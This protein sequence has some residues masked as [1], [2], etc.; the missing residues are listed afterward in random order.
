MNWPLPGGQ[1]T[2]Q[3]AAYKLRR[4]R[5]HSA[6]REY[7]PREMSVS[8]LTI[9]I[10]GSEVGSYLPLAK[11]PNSLTGSAPMAFAISR[12]STTSSL[13]SPRSNLETKDW[14]RPK[15][16]A[17]SDWVKCDESRASMSRSRK[18]SYLVEFMDFG[19]SCSG[20]YTA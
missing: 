17:K 18:R 20:N 11:V 7:F 9:F 15:R 5:L 13:R 19:T 16:A 8:S 1:S 12:N 14:G 3:I 10:V 4:V 2:S 6:D